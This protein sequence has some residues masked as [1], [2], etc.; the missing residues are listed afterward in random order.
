MEENGHNYPI[1]GQRQGHC[2]YIKEKENG[3]SKRAMWITTG[4]TLKGED[5]GEIRIMVQRGREM[6]GPDHL[7]YTY[8]LR[9]A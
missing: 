8:Q 3:I 9:I 4:T 7:L 1:N 6:I 5:H 2:R